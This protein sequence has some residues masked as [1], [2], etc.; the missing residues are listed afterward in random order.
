M[1]SVAERRVQRHANIFLAASDNDAESVLQFLDAGADVNAL[2]DNGYTTLHA[3]SSYNHTDLLRLLVS[4]GGDPNLADHEGDTPLFVA[5]TRE[6]CACLLALG[7]DLGH[8]NGEG[9]TALQH[10]TAEDEFPEVIAYLHERTHGGE[11]AGEGAAA[12]GLG[13]MRYEERVEGAIAPITGAAGEGE[14]LLSGVDEIPEETRAQIGEIMRK[15]GE[16]GVNRDDELRSIL[17]AALL[18]Q[19]FADGSARQRTE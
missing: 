5:E 8:E 10:V 11:G 19:G 6:M 13:Q 12:A 17:S 7:A 9:L 16:D 14:G 1:P 18:G 4:R 2:D 3:A 15:T